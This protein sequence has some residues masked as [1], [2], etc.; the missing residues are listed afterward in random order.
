MTQNLSKFVL[1]SHKNTL[2]CCN[3]YL[4]VILRGKNFEEK[5][6]GKFFLSKYHIFQGVKFFFLRFERSDSANKMGF[7]IGLKGLIC[8]KKND[9]N[10]F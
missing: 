3:S 4:N 6:W 5:T 10:L 7:K 8:A 1:G 9:Q 2:G